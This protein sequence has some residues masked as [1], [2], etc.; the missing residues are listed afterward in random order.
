MNVPLFNRLY[1]TYKIGTL[2][3]S[4]GLEAKIRSLGVPAASAR[5]ARYM[6]QRSAKQAGFFSAGDDRLILPAASPRGQQG[7]PPKGPEG[8][9]LRENEAGTESDQE[10]GVK[11]EM[12]VSLFRDLPGRDEGWPSEDRQ[13]W[14][15][16][17]KA[18]LD[19]LYPPGPTR[20]E[21]GT[22]PSFAGT[23]ADHASSAQA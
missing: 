10:I 6:F 12:I 22:R 2:P 15:V 16:M 11:H 13:R 17:L 1:E 19:Y 18:T 5:T 7:P 3:P 23:G 8:P 9:T 21:N 4:D 20:P 14:E